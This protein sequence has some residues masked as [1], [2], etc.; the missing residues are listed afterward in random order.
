[1]ILKNVKRSAKKLVIAVH[2]TILPSSSTK[3]G[4]N[5]K[6]LFYARQCQVSI[7]ISG[8]YKDQNTKVKKRSD[9]EIVTMN[10]KKSEFNVT[11]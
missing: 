10:T 5:C 7:Q 8:N 9:Y 4:R 6:V 1:M 3:H 2:C 11:W